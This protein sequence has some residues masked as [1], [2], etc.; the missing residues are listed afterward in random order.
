MSAMHDKLLSCDEL[1]NKSLQEL[2]KLK[3]FYELKQEDISKEDN[4]YTFRKYLIEHPKMHLLILFL[5]VMILVVSILM[6][7]FH[8]GFFALI[9]FSTVNI[10]IMGA[11]VNDKRC[12]A[13]D[14]NVATIDFMIKTFEDKTNRNKVFKFTRKARVVYE[15]L[16]EGEKNF[17]D[18][19]KFV[20]KTEKTLDKN[21]LKKILAED[22]SDVITKREGAYST[23]SRNISRTTIYKIR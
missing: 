1:S 23:T 22:L 14:K 7:R 19:L 12:Q 9:I 10:I 20:R 18:L 8:M 2:K 13:I 21:T 3:K 15:A 6:I 5:S 17:S 11:I 4:I 16:N